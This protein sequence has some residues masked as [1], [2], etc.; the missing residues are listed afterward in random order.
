MNDVEKRSRVS[1]VNGVRTGSGVAY[2]L[3]TSFADCDATLLGAARN[4][5]GLVAR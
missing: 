2:V 4:V 1:A 3:V 5:G